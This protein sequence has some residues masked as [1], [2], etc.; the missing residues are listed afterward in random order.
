MRALLLAISMPIVTAGFAL[1]TLAS[2]RTPAP[3]TRSSFFNMY[4]GNPHQAQ[5]AKAALST[6]QPSHV[7]KSVLV[8]ALSYA[9]LGAVALGAAK[10]ATA[11]GTG[12]GM[13]TIG[14][15]AA[16]AVILLVEFAMLGGGER[17]AKMM[18]GT[19]ADSYVTSIANDVSIRAGLPPPAHV[20]EI[21][22]DELNAFAAGFGKSDT[23][24]AVTSG[25]RKMLSRKELEAVIAHEIGHIR[26]KDMR[27]NMHVAVAIAGLGGVYEAGRFIMRSNSDSNKSKKK[28]EDS[29]ASAGTILMVGGLATRILGH[30]LQRSM[31]RGAEFEADRVAAELVGSDAMISAL[32]K[33]ETAAKARRSKG[34]SNGS[35]L[36]AGRAAAFSHAYISDGQA[37]STDIKLK[38]D[39]NDLWTIGEKAWRS[40][41]R[42]LSTHPPMQERIAALRE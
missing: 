9:G 23:T 36:R 6:A 31:S 40:A 20:Y 12:Y 14:A 18:G 35:P 34:G 27:T 25:L 13:I 1:P 11:Y 2:V 24:V 8:P 42:A 17:V 39:S 28:D 29:S 19:P 38:K 26:H 30:L 41:N 21:P 5:G 3:V 16:P 4:L 7:G 33:I 22:T 15:V 10:V 37:D 32:N